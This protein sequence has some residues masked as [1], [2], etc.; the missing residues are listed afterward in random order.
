MSQNTRSILKH[1][2]AQEQ[3]EGVGAR[4][5]RSIGTAKMRKFSPFLM[6]D[7]FNVIPPAGFPDHP[8]HG[9]E[10]IT[11]VRKGMVAH[12]DFTGSKGILRPGDLQF[13]TAGKAVCHSEMPVLMENGEILDGLQLWV[14]LPTNLKNTEPRYR[15]LHKENIPIAKP[16]ENLEIEVISGKSYGIES[17]KDLAYTPVD[18]YVYKARKKGS[19]FT[20]DFS[21]DYNVFLYIVKG[22]VAIGNEVFPQHS[23]IFFNTDGDNVQGIVGS[24]DTEFAIIGGQILRQ[25]TVQHGPFVEETVEKLVKVFHNYESYTGGFERALNW[26]SSIR[27]GIDESQA[28]N[29]K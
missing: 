4:V 21:R 14:D 15:D 10:T 22:S 16:D 17:V 1:F 27:N 24:D 5:R 3:A 19:A 6:L 13:M 9:Q 8:H 7:H 28:A 29:H 2:I 23:S 18:F 12:E 11:Y 20:Q 25:E 26:R